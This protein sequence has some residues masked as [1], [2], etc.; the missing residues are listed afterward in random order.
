MTRR[1]AIRR[2]VS[3]AL[4]ALQVSMA[5]CG[6]GGG[7]DGD[8]GTAAACAEPARKQFVLD[9]ARQWYLFPELL[10]SA[11]DAA[12]FPTAESL[13]EVVRSG[14]LA[15]QKGQQILES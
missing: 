3:C 4:P 14:A 1:T 12:G 15:I 10:P 2:F 9:V 7:G 6:G 5:G 13:L 8:N 11:V